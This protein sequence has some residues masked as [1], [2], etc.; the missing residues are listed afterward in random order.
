M[1]RT[2]PHELVNR[3]PLASPHRERRARAM[4]DLKLVDDNIPLPQLGDRVH[5]VLDLMHQ[6]WIGA[7][8]VTRQQN[9]WARLADT[10]TRHGGSHSADFPDQFRAHGLDIARNLVV[11]IN[12]GHIDVVQR[13]EQDLSPRK[14]RLRP[15]SMRQLAG[16]KGPHT[17]LALRGLS[18]DGMPCELAF[19]QVAERRVGVQSCS[20]EREP[21]RVWPDRLADPGAA[22]DPADDPR[23]TMPVQ[24]PS[25]GS[26]EQW[27]VAGLADG[28]VDRPRL[29]L[30]ERDGD[31][32]AALCE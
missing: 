7:L 2:W 18:D 21:Q 3:I 14:S 12:R 19:L 5:V 1:N 24:P 22:D 8:Q 17:N 29:P 4:R 20:D 27:P 32:L 13:T 28:Q 15:V 11:N 25:I 6:D 26:Q 30:R 23:G 10:Q 31:D 9:R 16:A